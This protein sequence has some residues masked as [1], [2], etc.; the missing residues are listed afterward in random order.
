[1]DMTTREHLHT[2]LDQLITNYSDNEYVSGRLRQHLEHIMP[3]ALE[4]DKQTQLLRDGRKQLLQDEQNEFTAKFLHMNRY[5]YSPQTE[6]FFWYDGVHFLIFREDDIQ[7]QIL[8]TISDG[9]VLMAWKH[10]IKN[11]ILKKIKESNPLSAI[12]ESET[13]Q[14]VLNQ[15]C[16]AFFTT[17]N[18]AKY[19]LTVIGDCIRLR[20]E[21]AAETVEPELVYL[22]AAGGKELVREIANLCYTLVGTSNI[23]NRIKFKYYDHAYSVCRLLQVQEVPDAKPPKGPTLPPPLAMY[24]MDLLCVAAH[25]STRYGGADQFLHQCTD[26]SLVEHAW[27]LKKHTPSTLV[28]AFLDVT[29]QVSV[30]ARIESKNMIY[31]WKKFIEERSLPNILFY[32]GLKTLLKEKLT[33]DEKSDAYLGVTSPQLPLISN[34]IK[35]WDTTMVAAAGA[36]E[37]L[38]LDEVCFLFKCYNTQVGKNNHHAVSEDFILKMIHHFWSDV[39]IEQDK[40]ILNMR[41]QMWDKHADIKQGLTQFKTAT[42]GSSSSSSIYDAYAHY[43]SHF[44]PK[45]KLL[46]SKRY[47]EKAVPHLVASEHLDTDGRLLATWRV[48][49]KINVFYTTLYFSDAVFF[50][51]CKI[52]LRF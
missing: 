8:S 9:R 11:N 18:H 51:R 29:V 21:A 50:W 25:Y 33:Y 2:L 17:R 24:L 22:M 35:F 15:L 1:M 14:F 52:N 23:L 43:C 26:L 49:W 31:L 39:I 28:T 12:P 47:F 44:K 34:F 5:F 27:F 20:G 4:N 16:P 3:A 32:E 46:V 38:E 37:E 41:S 48:D 42:I 36:H 13:I 30:D 19:F 7:H 45:N 10:K 40:F 6:L